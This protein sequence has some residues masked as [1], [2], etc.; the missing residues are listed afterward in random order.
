MNHLWNVAATVALLITAPVATF[1]QD[2]GSAT[3]SV[4]DYSPFV[5]SFIGIAS[6]GSTSAICPSGTMMLG[7]GGTRLKFIQ[8]ITPLCGTPNKE[9]T[10]TASTPVDQS[11][12]SST[13]TGFS[14]RCGAGKVVTG[15]GVAFNPNVDTY[16]FIGGVEI[17]CKPWMLS[18]WSEPSVRTA[19]TN[20][21]TW[22]Q[23]ARVTCTRQAQPVRSLKVR[24]T[25]S[26]K[27]IAIVCDEPSYSVN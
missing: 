17:E 13:A 27:G 3:I 4:V 21:E 25:T 2:P 14:L 9:G 20:F 26:T 24:A 16:P 8:K 12:I 1:A 23:K 7:I 15:V 11:A 19:T 10:A 18:L 6:I 22:P 5:S